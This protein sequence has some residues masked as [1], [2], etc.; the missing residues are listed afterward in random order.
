AT[1]SM[2]PTSTPSTKIIPAC[3]RSGSGLGLAI[4]KAV[5]DSHGGSVHLESPPEGG[6]RFVVTLPGSRARRPAEEPVRA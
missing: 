4:V 5:A 3:S 1:S 2:S 6:A